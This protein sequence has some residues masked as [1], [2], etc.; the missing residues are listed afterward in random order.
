[1]GFWEDC[2]EQ[3]TLFAADRDAGFHR[4]SCIGYAPI[5]VGLILSVGIGGVVYAEAT[6][7]ERI[8]Q[9]VLQERMRARNDCLVWYDFGKVPEG[10]TFEPAP[11]QDPHGTDQR[12]DAL[13]SRLAGWRRR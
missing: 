6:L 1:M 11:E 8:P 5:L 4:V 7:V 2:C 3:R 13:V 9:T 10:L 12:S